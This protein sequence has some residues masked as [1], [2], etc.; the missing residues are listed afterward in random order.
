MDILY[1]GGALIAAQLEGVARLALAAPAS[2]LYN[3]AAA[4]VPKAATA[5]SSSSSSSASS[6]CPFSGLIGSAS[7]CPGAR[8]AAEMAGKA[9]QKVDEATARLLAHHQQQPAGVAGG[10]GEG[11]TPTPS[12]C[13]WVEGRVTHVRRQPARHSFAYDVRLALVD[14]DAPPRWFVQEQQQQ[15]GKGGGGHAYLTA[16]EA[17]AAAGTSPGGRVLLLTLPAAAGYVQNPI[18]VYYCYEDGEDEE[19]EKEETEREEPKQQRQR[20][21]QQQQPA[22]ASAPAPSPPPPPLPV[23]RRCIAEVTNTPWGERVSF[24]FDPRGSS[25]PK[26]LH[27]S[28][29]MDM[30]N[31]WLL[32]ATDPLMGGGGGGGGGAGDNGSSGENNNDPASSSSPSPN[33]VV[34]SVLVDHPEL[35]RYFDAQFVGKVVVAGGRGKGAAAAAADGRSERSGLATLWRYGFLPQ[36]VAVWIYVHAVLLALKGVRVQPK[37]RADTYES[38]AEQALAAAARGGNSSSGPIPAGGGSA[39][40]WAGRAFVW[41]RAPRWPW[42]LE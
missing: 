25:V 33:R 26:S 29:F 1:K 27:V 2:F 39:A 16:Q 12:I 17:R 42:Y 35:G 5:P 24:V 9:G 11:G 8:M 41:Q 6:R 40:A 37:P 38:R 21:Q 4:A 15:R 10:V 13:W 20:R 23:L 3:V 14:L 22:R 7:A 34:L 30:R 19:A 31:V 28:P 18:S 36:R 32:K